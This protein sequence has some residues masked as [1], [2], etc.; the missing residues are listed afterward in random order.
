MLF[1]DKCFRRRLQRMIGTLS[2]NPESKEDVLQESFILLQHLEQSKPRQSASWYLQACKFR[3]LHILSRGRSIDSPKRASRQVPLPDDPDLQ[4]EILNPLAD[5]NGLFFSAVSAN[6][7]ET[8]LGARLSRS[9]RRILEL[10]RDG[11][12]LRQVGTKLGIS[13]PTVLQ[14]RK[15]IARYARQIGLKPEPRRTRA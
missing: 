8:L 12:S 2:C 14:H 4:D 13:H 15:K 3:A 7:I 10:L 1:E 5:R 9:D 11:H 6:D